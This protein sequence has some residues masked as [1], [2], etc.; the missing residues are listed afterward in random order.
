MN[1]AAKVTW[2][3]DPGYLPD[4][5]TSFSD[6]MIKGWVTSRLAEPGANSAASMFWLGFLR[7]AP[8]ASQRLD[9]H[10]ECVD[11]FG[12]GTAAALHISQP[13]HT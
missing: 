5:V 4:R 10:K 3:S 1:F 8:L 2:M 12:L 11:G 7:R 9:V 13:H 6:Q